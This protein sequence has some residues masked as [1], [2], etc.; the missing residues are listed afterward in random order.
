MAYQMAATA[1]TVNYLEGPSPV[2]GLLKG[3]PSNFSAAFYAI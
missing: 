2:A 1:V 3:N